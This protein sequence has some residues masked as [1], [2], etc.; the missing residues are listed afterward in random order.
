[1][2]SLASSPQEA[3]SSTGTSGDRPLRRGHRRRA[4]RGGLLG[5]S[6]FS[7]V[8]LPAPVLEMRRSLTVRDEEL[9][10]EAL[11]EAEKSLHVDEFPVGAVVVLSDEVVARAH[12][13]GASQR[14]LLRRPLRDEN[15]ASRLAR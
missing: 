3:L 14:R 12:R 13:V 2:S 10:V 11:V 8:Q 7:L 5:L 1:M 6:P 15:G 9:M 4:N